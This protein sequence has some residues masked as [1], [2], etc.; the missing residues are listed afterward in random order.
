MSIRSKGAVL[1]VA[2][3]VLGIAV[4]VRFQGRD[5]YAAAAGVYTVCPTGCDFTTVSDAAADPSTENGIVLLTDAYVFD[6]SLEATN[7]WFDHDRTIDCD[8]G[9]GTY[10]N[11][12]EATVNVGVAQNV[13]IEHC[14]FENVTFDASFRDNVSFINNTFSPAA[15]S[16]ITLTVVDGFTVT[17]NK[18]LQH[19]QVQTAFNGEIHHNGFECR[20]GNNCLSLSPA[21]G[22]P[23]DYFDPTLVP[24]TINIHH[25][26]FIN[27]NP[28]TGGDW[29]IFN[30]GLD[31]DFSDNLLQSYV[32]LDNS[33]LV[34]MTL[35][36]GRFSLD[37]NTFE[38]PSKVAP[39][40]NATWGLNLRFGDD[41]LLVAADHN[42]FRMRGPE[43]T[44]IGAYHSSPT[45]PSVLDLDLTYNLCASLDN[46]D[47]SIGFNLQYMP[48]LVTLTLGNDYLGMSNIAHPV[49]DNNSLLSA[50]DLAATTVYG[51][52]LF[53]TED[54]NP[55]DDWE[56]VPMS[57][58]LDVNGAQDIGAYGAA[59]V[60]DY[61]IDDDCAVDYVSCH[62][63]LS[64][65]IG[66]VVRSG[67]T[68]HV[69]D[70]TYDRFAVD[71]P[72]TGVTITGQ[73]DGTVVDAAGTGNG[74]ALTGMSGSTVSDLAVRNASQ[75]SPYAYD[76]TR[77]LFIYAGNDYDDTAPLSLPADATLLIAPGPGCTVYPYTADGTDV[78]SAVTD[79]S[80]DWNLGLV[81]VFGNKITIVAPNNAI[82]SG[83]AL[84]S[85][86]DTQCG[87][88]GVT[89]D[90]FVPSFFTAADHL[91]TYDAGAVAGAGIT[92]RAGITDPPRIDTAADT[93]TFAGL[94][95][96]DAQ[97]NVFDRLALA[98]NS[99]G[100]VL[101]AT[102]T[103]NTFRRSTL[104]SAGAAVESAADGVTSLV[105]STFAVAS[106]LQGGSGSIQISYSVRA[107]VRA[108]GSRVAGATVTVT[109]A[110]GA[111]ACT[112]TSGTDGLTPFC[113]PVLVTVV[114]AGGPYVAT[115]GGH[116]PLTF[117]ATAAGYGSYTLANMVTSPFT[118]VVLAVTPTAAESSGDDT[119]TGDSAPV[120][121]PGDGLPATPSDTGDS[122]TAGTADG[123]QQPD[124]A[125]SAGAVTF[126]PGRVLL[127]HLIA[128][129]RGPPG[130]PAPRPPPPTATNS[131]T[132]Q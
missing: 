15:P 99:R 5:L 80:S 73:G 72:V 58:F 126:P 85:Y 24:S 75:A 64:A 103:G 47:S 115:A 1:A 2:V 120:V 92:V 66:K 26:G 14:T 76:A 82:A 112:Q 106:L 83:P 62:S 95:L 51:D 44:C 36:K 116:N 127:G 77:M 33:Y 96:T 124:T 49:T 129:A 100:A 123:D 46:S 40:S 22:D 11:A 132:R 128:P 119:G 89:V 86:L 35:E 101:D 105:D 68:V 10:G 53:R 90:A 13:A 34:M 7:P 74:I 84:V 32:T 18:G 122:D 38:F 125:V 117:R 121:V 97:D 31:I 9:A 98:D 48:A 25:N 50:D 81:D 107:D 27:Y 45:D 20:F 21:G 52:A 54:T 61:T 67:D 17:D 29:V 88:P 12:S 23:G 19:L 55:A 63:H 94:F 28:S 114:S 56:L 71:R 118:S 102:S 69:A 59:R 131:P 30:A 16:S 8:P 79:P 39:A 42:T 104:T 108:G 78:T 41:D 113:D 87:A 60:S 4:A 91:F 109:D 93:G 65:T 37:R 57:R 43:A 3:A 110:V 6:A 111:T 130:G 70:G